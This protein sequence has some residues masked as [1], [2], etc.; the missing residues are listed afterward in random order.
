MNDLNEKINNA[1]QHFQDFIKDDGDAHEMARKAEELEREH[2]ATRE[3]KAKADE[4]EKNVN[5]RTYISWSIF[6][7][8]IAWLVFVIV[9]VI[10]AGAN[11]LH[12]SDSVL[13][14]LLAT[15]TTNI[16]GMWA[17]ILRYLFPNNK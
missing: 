9:V 11:V 17:I 6:G 12:L 2:H 5:Q 14:T 4:A 15:T 7:V 16:I 8:M 3:A 1:N 10:L 13:M